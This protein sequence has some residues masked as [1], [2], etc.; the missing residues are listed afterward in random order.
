MHGTQDKYKV[1]IIYIMIE[2]IK[3]IIIF[4]KK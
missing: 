3:N 4:V 2:I 1:L